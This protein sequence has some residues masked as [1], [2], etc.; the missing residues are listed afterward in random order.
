MIALVLLGGLTIRF[1][2]PWANQ[3][4]VAWS[5]NKL[6]EALGTEASISAV[7]LTS[8]GKI[9]VEDLWIQDPLGHEKTF[10]YSPR[11][12]VSINPMTV[13]Q[14]GINLSRVYIKRPL[15][16]IYRQEDGKWNVQNFGKKDKTVDEAAKTESEEKKKGPPFRLRIHEVVLEKC[17]TELNGVFG[18]DMVTVLDHMGGLEITG[19]K[20]EIYLWE[21][22]FNSSYMTLTDME[23]DGKLTY[24]DKLMTFERFEIR[25]DS[26]DIRLEGSIDFEGRDTIDLDIARSRYDLSHIPPRY[27]LRHKV[28]GMVDLEATLTGNLNSPDIIARV[29]DAEGVTFDYPYSNL[30]CLF[31]LGDGAIDVT[32]LSADFLG[33]AIEGEVSFYLRESPKAF[34]VDL[35]VV[36]LDITTM[37]LNIPERFDSDFSG[38]VVA[39]G[40]GF[41][42]DSHMSTILLDLDESRFREA[43]I[44]LIQAQVL[45]RGEGFHVISSHIE[46]DEGLI[47]L[48]G[49]LGFGGPD[50]DVYTESVPIPILRHL[51]DMTYKIDGYLY[52]SVSLRDSY[53][54][55]SVEGQIVVRDGDIYGWEFAGLEGEVDVRQTGGTIEG[56]LDMSAFMLERGWLMSE[57]AEMRAVFD[58]EGIEFESLK[59]RMGDSTLVDGTGRLEYAGDRIRLF[60]DGLNL[61]YRDL[62]VS[63]PVLS[64]EL[65]WEKKEFEIEDLRMEIGGG[66]ISVQGEMAFPQ[67]IE[68]DG[69][70]RSVRLDA[71]DALIPNGYGIDGLVDLE[72]NVTNS[73]GD[74][75]IE[76]SGSVRNPVI[77]GTWADS[78]LAQATYA[79]SRLRI[80]RASIDG[81]GHKVG[82]VASLPIEIDLFPFRVEG[83]ATEEVDVRI[84]LDAFPLPA[85][86]ILTDEVDFIEGV[87]EGDIRL[88]GKLG[89]PLWEGSGRVRNGEGVVNLTNTYFNRMGMNVSF[90][91]DRIEVSDI[92]AWLMGEGDL[93]GLG[94]IWMNGIY[95]DSVEFAL[96]A[97]DYMVNQIRHV[98][99]L[100]FDSD[101]TVTGKID[102]PEITGDVVVHHGVLDIPVS[103]NETGRDEGEPAPYELRLDVVA[104]NDL[105]IRNSDMNVEISLDIDM[106]TREGKIKPVGDLDVIRGTYTYFGTIF[107]IREGEINFFG[108]HPIDPA[109]NVLTTRTIRGRVFD[110]G[111]SRQVNNE[112]HL[113]VYGTYRDV[114]FDIV[115]YDANGEVIP[116]D[117]Q[118]AM[119]LLLANM[120]NEEFDQQAAPNQQRVIGQIEG[121]LAQQTSSLIQ[122]VSKLDVLELRTNLFS[123]D[124]ETGRAQ[125][126]VGEYLVEDFFVSYSQDIL[127]PSINNIAVEVYLGRKSS[128]VGQTDSKGRQYSVELRYRMSY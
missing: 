71:L 77:K 105:W 6:T 23:V 48:T 73:L 98:S 9:V 89:N 43:G 109:L 78:V 100:I 10:F 62:E 106:V 5:S 8:D 108:S 63:V 117:R 28:S 46:L 121:I 25:R 13:V 118:K 42:R 58:R 19:K 33:G 107:D 96:V 124:T 116:I 80:E 115:V 4:F 119:T 29:Y 87:V 112:F 16:Y 68:F 64:S 84:D 47:E 125:V 83:I 31:R 123:G 14:E 101:L 51:I 126:T 76:L 17:V 128:V 94:T 99:N 3:R 52:G 26:T 53:S 93:A 113:T 12:E 36:G 114:E 127:D 82:M 45:A 90:E 91:G 104:E 122:P 40:S 111:G 41:S 75:E 65:D 79:N 81:G 92:S 44:D 67:S 21:T 61:I 39:Y 50:I 20:V 102:H 95:P 49:E 56:Y 57:E 59:L 30:S 15:V 110:E 103:T 11:V 66:S 55:P 97:E 18:E 7:T 37:P 85:L 120:T 38:Q 27:G 22:H 69:E 86:R 74:P 88:G 2:V 54:K 1:L 32:E 35:D 70:V 24:D 34:R 72:V 60:T